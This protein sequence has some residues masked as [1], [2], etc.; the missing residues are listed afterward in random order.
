MKPNTATRSRERES[1]S[2]TAIGAAI[3]WLQK[4][5]DEHSYGDTAEDA[6]NILSGLRAVHARPALDE[7]LALIGQIAK[8]DQGLEEINKAKARISQTDERT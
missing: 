7:L 1:Q 6:R 5:I 2:L 3:D 4:Y 8:S